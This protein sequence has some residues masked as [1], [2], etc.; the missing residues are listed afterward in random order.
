MA[1]MLAAKMSSASS[2]APRKIITLGKLPALSEPSLQGAWSRARQSSKQVPHFIQQPT[3]R[4]D[5]PNCQHHRS[6]YSDKVL[7][8]QL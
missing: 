1:E 7:P 6:R 5:L 4:K 8:V 2:P 3:Y